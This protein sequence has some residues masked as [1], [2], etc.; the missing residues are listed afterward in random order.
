MPIASSGPVAAAVSWK[1][2]MAR[3][4]VGPGSPVGKRVSASI[5]SGAEPTR[6][7]NLVPPDSIDPS[8]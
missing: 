6:Q 7:T 5:R 3:A 8:R 2:A 4:R 1:K